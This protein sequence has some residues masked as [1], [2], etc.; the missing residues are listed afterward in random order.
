MRSENYG[1]IAEKI[2]NPESN[3]F[4]GISGIT[5]EELVIDG[6]WEI[7]LPPL[8]IQANEW[9]ETM[10]CVSFAIANAIETI[11]NR[12]YSL[13]R[14]YSDRA[15]AKMS[16]TKRTGNEMS[17]VANTAQNGL[18]TESQWPFD[19]MDIKTWDEF[20]KEIPTDI[21]VKA[22]DFTEEFELQWE[23]V[24]SGDIE[25]IKKA[26]KY[27]PLAVAIYAYTAQDA[28]GYYTRTESWPNHLVL[29]YG[30]EDGKCWWIYDSYKNCFKKLAWDFKFGAK[31]KFNLIRINELMPKYNFEN[32]TLLQL[33]EGT[34]GFGLYLD[35]KLFVDDLDKILASWLV[36]NSGNTSGMTRAVTNEIWESLPKFNLKGDEI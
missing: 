12:K 14:N 4:G 2:I 13:D 36:R 33:V 35:G 28:N 21:L 15:L 10:S 5:G 26:L 29:L 18:L 20:Y 25:N 1:Y 8:E 32:N 9:L 7:W 27:S 16:G 34:G 19:R 31:I 6:N 24:F 30:Y 11:L 22:K 17:V 3:F 23:W